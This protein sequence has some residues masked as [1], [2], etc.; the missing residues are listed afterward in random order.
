[1]PDL[2][3]NPFAEEPDQLLT[4]QRTQMDGREFIREA[5]GRW[6]DEWRNELLL[7]NGQIVIRKTHTPVWTTHSL[8]RWAYQPIP[9][10]QWFMENWIPLGQVVGLY[11]KPGSRKSTLLLQWMIASCL[12]RGFGPCQLL[13]GPCYGLFC[14]DS[15]AE[16]AR[17]AQQ[18]LTG[19]DASFDDL[20]DCH[21]ESLV[22]AQLTHFFTFRRSGTMT[23]TP[24]WEKFTS[25]LDHL[26]P[27]FV[28]LDVAANF[29][30]GNEINRTETTAFLR[31]LDQTANERKFAL[32]F[33]YH[34]SLRGLK[35]GTLA[36][37]NTAWEGSVR[38]RITIEDPTD[39]EEADDE[40]TPI[41]R[42]PNQSDRRTIT[43]VKSNYARAGATINLTVKDGFFLPT[44]LDPDNTI[45]TVADKALAERTF[46]DRLQKTLAQGNNVSNS[47]N[48]RTYAPHA[49]AGDGC[50]AKILEGAMRRLFNRGTLKFD[51]AKR[52]VQKWIIIDN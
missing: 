26:K 19:Y 34:P 30:S 10:L 18:I 45:T 44:D 29:F 4:L 36:S 17:R 39:N 47:K 22:D 3:K 40:E 12:G 5:D 13:T 9:P 27:V 33:S 32:L 2:S 1:M 20:E 51:G 15:H 28:V 14:E 50:N 25:D 49:L 31:R 11:G 24:A 43:L 46:L 16:I 52:H 8:Q 6:F 7:E 23:P 42:L 35:E 38:A 41:Y 48:S 21:A 37:G